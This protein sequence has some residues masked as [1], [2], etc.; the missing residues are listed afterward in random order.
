MKCKTVK[1]TM[2]TLWMSLHLVTCELYWHLCLQDV[3][4]IKINTVL[5][6]VPEILFNVVFFQTID[7]KCLILNN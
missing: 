7:A 1:E 4:D 5:Y 2:K 3:N 6:E